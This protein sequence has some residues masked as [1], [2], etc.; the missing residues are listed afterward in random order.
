MVLIWLSVLEYA[1]QAQR[2]TAPP[3]VSGRHTFT[4]CRLITAA[5]ARAS[6]LYTRK[7]DP[8]IIIL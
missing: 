8:G 5:L 6:P 1:G 3:E 2:T 4:S 7:A